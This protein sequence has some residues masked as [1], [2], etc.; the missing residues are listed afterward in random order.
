MSKGGMRSGALDVINSCGLISRSY[1]SNCLVELLLNPNLLA[2]FGGNCAPIFV[3]LDVSIK[4]CTESQKAISV[5]GL[6]ITGVTTG[7]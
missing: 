3:D 2:L 7:G 6:C 1:L 4:S 5:F